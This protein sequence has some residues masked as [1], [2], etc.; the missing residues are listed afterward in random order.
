MDIKNLLEKEFGVKTSYCSIK[1]H[2]EKTTGLKGSFEYTVQNLNEKELLDISYMNKKIGAFTRIFGFIYG[3]GHMPKNVK[4]LLFTGNKEAL[5]EVK[6]DLLTLGFCGS[7]IQTKEL[8]NTIENRI[9]IGK[10]TSFYVDSAALVNLF[11]FLGAPSG[12]KIITPYKI[13]DWIMNGTKFVKREF[14]RSLYGCEGYSPKIK[15]KN[16][17]AV[18]LRMHKSRYLKQNMLEFFEQIKKILKEF[19]VEA[20][21]KIQKLG[22]K[23]KDGHITDS[24]EL[25]LKSN[26]QNIFKFFSRIS[27]AFEKEKILKARV[28]A[29]Y[30]RYKLYCL[31]QQKQ[32]AVQILQETGNFSKRGLARKYNCSLDFVINQF[33][34]KKINSQRKFPNFK[35]W[36]KEYYAGNGSVFN[37]ITEIKEI[38]CE[39]VRDIACTKNHNFIANGIIAHNC[40]YSSRIIEPLQSRCAIF[41]F[42]PLNS[43][44]ITERLIEIAKKEGIQL[45]DDA[46]KA[47]TYVSQGDLRKAI[48]VLQA[49][50]SIESKIKE[51]TI[52]AV[53]SKAKPE[54]IKELIKLALEKK[55]LEAREK[56]DALLY[57]YG[58]S[59]EDVVLQLYRELIEVDEKEIDGKTKIE[60]IEKIGEANF[61][62]VEGANERI[63][64]E[65]LIAQFMKYKK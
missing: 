12:D 44:D 17:E 4:R 36:K 33:K 9:V 35:K 24:Y 43:K 20:Y 45:N 8:K 13:P 22:T 7:E 40:N 15:N 23:R 58:M 21:I 54:E 46:L 48:N 52:Y 55:F 29:E 41:R 1:K 18:T 42:K 19:D 53:S 32:K 26:N 47:V 34:G 38:E 3:D 61:R 27:Y 6:K 50:S 31:E 30:L 39:D 11:E 63:Q 65:A 57:D 10:T 62:I 5:K 60:L 25:I 37:E 2:L 64:L 51:D 28:S 59:G 14:I 16:F 56:L 49:S